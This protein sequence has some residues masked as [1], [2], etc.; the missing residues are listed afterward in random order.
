MG[1]GNKSGG[2][3]LRKW[4]VLAGV[5]AVVFISVALMMR[6]TPQ[7]R[8]QKHASV[9]LERVAR[10]V[11]VYKSESGLMVQELI[12][13]SG[14]I[15]V[16]R[17]RV[18]VDYTGR[19]LSDGKIFDTSMGKSP[20]V[21]DLEEGK[22]IAGW[23]EALKMMK[24]GGKYRIWVPPHLGYGSQEMGGGKIPANSVLVFDIELLAISKRGDAL[25]GIDE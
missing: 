19:L 14:G 16:D 9:I 23:V 21:I 5:L 24:V 12:P 2:T 20:L 7:G 22:I 25:G 18:V 4:L 17:D 6:N 11:E 8:D 15:P 13:G 3:S 1:K 10:N